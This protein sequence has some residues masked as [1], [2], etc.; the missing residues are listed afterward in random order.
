[1][2]EG[3]EGVLDVQGYG[4]V[5][6]PVDDAGFLNAGEVRVEVEEVFPLDQAAR[7]HYR[8]ETGHTRGK[9]VLRVAS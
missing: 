1:V 8:G 6:G 3:S 9:L 5:D 7:A 2:A 4:G